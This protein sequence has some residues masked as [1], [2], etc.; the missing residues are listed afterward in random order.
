MLSTPAGA[1]DGCLVLLCL[2]A[3]SWGAIAQCVAPI[4]QVFHDLMRGKPFPTCGMSGPGS[5]GA[6]QWA[7]A[8][9][10]CPPQYTQVSYAESGPVYACSFS[11]VI[12]S[13]VDG[14]LW[15]KTWWTMGGDSVTE[16]SAAAKAKLGQWN[17]R[18]DDDYAQW[19]AAQTPPPAPDC[20]S[21]GGG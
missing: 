11:G 9:D 14:Q 12:T 8:P 17:S 3:P 1:V 19:L 15:S 7:Y 13:V 16:Y 18:F 2:A 21:C 4:V 10:N 5:S 20:G 6:N